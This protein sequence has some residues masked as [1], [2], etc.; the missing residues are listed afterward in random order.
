MNHFVSIHSKN[1]SDLL[2]TTK[3][4]ANVCEHTPRSP[5]QNNVAN[6]ETRKTN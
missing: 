6:P 5:L 1:E 2:N 3:S 4:E